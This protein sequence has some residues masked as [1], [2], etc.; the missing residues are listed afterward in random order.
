MIST[1][2]WESSSPRLNSGEGSSPRF[3]SGESSSLRWLRA[4]S[5]LFD[6]RNY[7]TPG[8]EPLPSLLPPSTLSS[9]AGDS[10]SR[11][12]PHPLWTT[13]GAF[14]AITGRRHNPS[15]SRAFGHAA[16]LFIPFVSARS[17]LAVSSM[18]ISITCSGTALLAIIR[19]LLFRIL[20]PLRLD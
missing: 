9:A 8:T 1:K 7:G 15:T 14:E 2:I 19:P 20:L 16:H 17:V 11:A 5:V 10:Q 12:R 18:K 13:C 4:V 3:N 6:R